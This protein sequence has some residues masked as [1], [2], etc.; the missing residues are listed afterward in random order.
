M[1]VQEYKN[2]YICMFTVAEYSAVCNNNTGSNLKGQQD[3][4][5][6]ANYSTSTPW[7]IMQLLTGLPLAQKAP[8]CKS[9][10]DNPF[11]G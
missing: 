8:V 7:N 6:Y 10:K 9:E 2:L 4:V 5:G 1:F 3:E 11:S